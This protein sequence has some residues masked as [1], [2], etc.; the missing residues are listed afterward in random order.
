MLMIAVHASAAAVKLFSTSPVVVLDVG[1][2]KFK[3]TLATLTTGHFISHRFDVVKLLMQC[4]QA[5][6][7]VVCWQWRSASHFS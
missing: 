7:L 5:V 1:G 2:T 4:S 3:T 6:Q